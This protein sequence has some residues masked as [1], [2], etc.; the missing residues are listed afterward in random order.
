MDRAAGESPLGQPPIVR[1]SNL[2][3]DVGDTKPVE[4]GASSSSDDSVVSTL[5]AVCK[6]NGFD[7]NFVMHVLQ[8][9]TLDLPSTL[10]SGQRP[11]SGAATESSDCA[12]GESPNQ[13]VDETCDTRKERNKQHARK[14]RIRQK[15]RVKD[16]ERRLAK[17]HVRNAE[18]R[19]R[20]SMAL[21]KTKYMRQV[22]LRRLHGDSDSDDLGWEGNPAVAD[23]T[24]SEG[25]SSSRQELTNMRVG[26]EALASS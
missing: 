5:L 13:A 9:K 26:C 7:S 1:H 18:L 10:Q 24:E 16:M 20:Y 3:M 17:L 25:A 22:V 6:A 12:S 15:M 8:D 4:M 23:S 21:L 2:L 19:K 11:T 14:S